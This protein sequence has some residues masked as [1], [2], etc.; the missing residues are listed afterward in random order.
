[1]QMKLASKA[2]FHL[3]LELEDNTS[4]TSPLTTVDLLALFSPTVSV[5]TSGHR[6]TLQLLAELL[7][8]FK[9]LASHPF[10]TVSTALPHALHT[11]QPSV[12]REPSTS[13]P[14][15]PSQS[16]SPLLASTVT[17]TPHGTVA[18]GATLRPSTTDDPHNKEDDIN[19]S[20]YIAPKDVMQKM[21]L[22][23]W[24]P[25]SAQRSMQTFKN[26]T[27]RV[28]VDKFSFLSYDQALFVY[29]ALIRTAHKKAL[30]AKKDG[31]SATIRTLKRQLCFTRYTPP[32][33]AG[34]LDCRREGNPMFSPPLKFKHPSLPLMK[35][36]RSKSFVAV[37]MMQGVIAAF[38][39][40]E[41]DFSSAVI[42]FLVSKFQNPSLPPSSQRPSS[43]I[44]RP[45]P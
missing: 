11:A 28:D 42:D 25:S 15:L 39:S 17:P 6:Q 16:Q 18:E 5:E 44:L 21:T 1:M 37:G 7:I 27:L 2:R 19:A 32:W 12:A 14:S 13:D 35:D 43:E 4:A 24:F 45:L 30:E 23:P 26:A 8:D 20:W 33:F 31:T 34:N 10:P 3:L 9:L 38:Y 36:L 22:P 29:R 40:K 41:P